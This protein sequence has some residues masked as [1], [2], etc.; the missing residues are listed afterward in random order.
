MRAKTRWVAGTA[1]LAVVLVG[2]Q[3]IEETAH[4]AAASYKLEKVANTDFT[5]I[6]LQAKAAE[7]LGIATAP[8]QAVMTAAGARTVVL[9]DAVIYGTKGETWA[10]ASPEPLVFV[11]QNIVVDYIEGNRVFLTAGPSSGTAVVTVGVAELYG[12]EKGFGK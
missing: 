7:R 1:L 11:R 10:F 5:R 4:T 12:L 9:S 8:V 2:C 3:R 6:T